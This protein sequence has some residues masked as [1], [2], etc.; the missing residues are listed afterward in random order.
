[1]SFEKLSPE[2][3]IRIIYLLLKDMISAELLTEG[4]V[5]IVLEKLERIF[6]ISDDELQA[7]IT[8]LKID[9]L[10]INKE[11]QI[12]KEYIKEVENYIIQLIK[13]QN[14]KKISLDDLE[15]LLEYLNEIYQD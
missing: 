2:D 4:E 6:D 14:R 5:Y 8:S 15:K 9:G 12:N 13:G 1:M 11:L 3:K 7:I 10:L